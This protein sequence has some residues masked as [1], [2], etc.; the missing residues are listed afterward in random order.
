[1]TKGKHGPISSKVGGT[2]EKYIVWEE[3][4]KRY[5]IQITISRERR[6]HG[7]RHGGRFKT[8][9]EAVRARDVL[10]DKYEI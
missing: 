7:G 6:I 4:I 10:M 8:L 3:A 9:A 1:M 2:G 5:R